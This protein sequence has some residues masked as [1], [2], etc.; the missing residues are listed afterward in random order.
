LYRRE[1]RLA[2]SQREM[3]AFRHYQTVKSKLGK[4]F[5]QLQEQPGPM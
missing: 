5:K 4:I 1:G 2:D 3:D